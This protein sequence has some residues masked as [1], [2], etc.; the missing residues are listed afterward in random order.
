MST[1]TGPRTESDLAFRELLSTVLAECDLTRLQVADA[2][3]RKLGRRITISILND[4]TTRTKM[5]AR[6]P[7]A[8]VQALCEV[9]GDDRIARYCLRPGCRL[10]LDLGTEIFKAEH[11]KKTLIAEIMAADG[12]KTESR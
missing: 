5:T 11:K 10:L 4:Y 6:F 2:L 8:Y 3:S 9:T 7:A 12:Y 1:V